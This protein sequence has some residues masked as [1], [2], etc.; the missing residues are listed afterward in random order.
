MRS[1]GQPARGG[2]LSTAFRHLTHENSSIHSPWAS[3]F[4]AERGHLQ[5]KQEER[6]SR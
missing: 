6:A 1:C 2:Q 5:V 3:H 4:E